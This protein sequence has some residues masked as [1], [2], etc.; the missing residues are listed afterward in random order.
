MARIRTSLIALAA[1]LVAGTVGAQEV[2]VHA[3]GAAAHAVTEP[4]MRELG[5]GGGGALAAELRLLPKSPLKVGVQV[6][7]TALALSQGAAPSDPTLARRQTGTML[8]ASGGLRLSLGGLW[9]DGG[10]GV[11]LTGASPRPLVE[12]ALG[13]DFRIGRS[14]IE[15]GPFAGYQQIVQTSDSVRPEDGRVV[16][17]GLHF[18]LGS[19]P[20][21]A[22][23]PPMMEAKRRDPGPKPPPAV[24][25]PKADR[26]GD[27]VLDEEDA[28][29][30]VAGVRTEVPSTNGCPETPVRLVE[31][32][33]ELPDRIHF[34]FASPKV[35]TDSIDLVHKVA[36]YVV[37]RG[38]VVKI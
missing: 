12:V 5:W 15:F 2:R 1:S 37:A 27:G 18:V 10:A 34:E 9:V 7:T 22:A 28:C 31:D 35:S 21:N 38:D 13:W 3:K 36:E 16:M 29:P 23:P 25:A 32:R 6:Q 20:A 14:P 17:F 24:A 26:D 33:L 30:D 8:G 19:R 4:Q 11:A